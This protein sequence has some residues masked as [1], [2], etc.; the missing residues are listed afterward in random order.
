MNLTHN[1]IIDLPMLPLDMEFQVG[2][3][4]VLHEEATF[5]ALASGPLLSPLVGVG[6]AGEL[7]VD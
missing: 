1:F 6:V 2:R 5:V 7:V 4:Y 3:I